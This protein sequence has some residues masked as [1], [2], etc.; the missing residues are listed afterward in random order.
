[1]AKPVIKR[2][3]IQRIKLRETPPDH[4]QT[5]K[6]LSHLPGCGNDAAD[7]SKMANRPA[8]GALNQPRDLWLLL[9]V[10]RRNSLLGRY[11][12]MFVLWL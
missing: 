3:E 7:N 6:A 1:M 12:L 5:D 8:A 2:I 4:G 11:K 10:A 9:N